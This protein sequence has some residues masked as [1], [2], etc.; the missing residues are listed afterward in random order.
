MFNTQSNFLYV[1]PCNFKN[2]KYKEATRLSPTFFEGRP[3]FAFN[4]DVLETQFSASS[5]QP[6][7]LGTTSEVKVKETN[8]R[9]FSKNISSQ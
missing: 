9:H 6:R 1:F 2:I 7:K 3:I 8:L 5:D 4:S